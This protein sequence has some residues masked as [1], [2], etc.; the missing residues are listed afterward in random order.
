MCED[1]HLLIS[2]KIH[3]HSIWNIP[4]TWLEFSKCIKT[5]VLRF[6]FFFFVMSI[7]LIYL[8]FEILYNLCFS[9]N[10]LK[11]NPRATTAVRTRFLVFYFSLCGQVQR[12]FTERSMLK[13]KNWHKC[14]VALD[15][16]CYPL[17]TIQ[18]YVRTTPFFFLILIICY[19]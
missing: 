4:K 7:Y 5:Y 8:L 19:Y 11:N 13:K 15:K 16:C 14:K 1:N 2:Q 12:N 3:T 17:E 6:F 18:S 10:L 9:S